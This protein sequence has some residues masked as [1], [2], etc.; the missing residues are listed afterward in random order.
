MSL[1]RRNFEGPFLPF[2]QDEIV[3][4]LYLYLFRLN[5]KT[6]H[7]VETWLKDVIPCDMDP[8]RTISLPI[9]ASDKCIDD[10]RV[11]SSF[12][13]RLCLLACK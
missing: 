2:D 1:I 8:S 9:R 7:R 12:P 10:F 6:L 3:A 13:V 11:E 5:G 4:G